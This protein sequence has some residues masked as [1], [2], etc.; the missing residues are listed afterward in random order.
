MSANQH[1]RLEQYRKHYVE[2]IL[3]YCQGFNLQIK[4]YSNAPILR[5]NLLPL[6]YSVVI[7]TCT[8]DLSINTSLH[9]E[10]NIIFKNCIWRE[11]T[12]PF[13]IEFKKER[14]SANSLF[15]RVYAKAWCIVIQQAWW[16]YTRCESHGDIEKNHSWN[17]KCIAQP[18]SNIQAILT[19]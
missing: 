11:Q 10:S 19:N 13:E 14:L 4:Q 5:H 9:S 2:R 16:L 8:K 15:R 3:H 12:I 1:T 6:I 18:W 17:M 7:Y